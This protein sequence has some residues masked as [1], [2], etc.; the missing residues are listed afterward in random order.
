MVCN[1]LGLTLWQFAATKLKSW[2]LLQA[3]LIAAKAQGADDVADNEGKGIMLFCQ[4]KGSEENGE[5]SG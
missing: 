3:S 4:Y 5:D 2:I 1:H